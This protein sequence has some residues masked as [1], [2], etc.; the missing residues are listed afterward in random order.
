M[1]KSS[2]RDIKKSCSQHVGITKNKI[3]FHSKHI[4]IVSNFKN[5]ENLHIFNLN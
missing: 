4:N 2:K 5:L 1:N 3:N